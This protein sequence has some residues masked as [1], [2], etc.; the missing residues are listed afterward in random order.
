M[1]DAIKGIFKELNIKLSN[2]PL[3]R[4]LKVGVKKLLYQKCILVNL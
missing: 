4:F 1:F 3:N 2:T